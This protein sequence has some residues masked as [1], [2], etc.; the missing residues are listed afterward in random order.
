MKRTKK[1]V[2]LFVMACLLFS[3]IAACSNKENNTGSTS[4]SPSASASAPAEPVKEDPLKFVYH[5]LSRDV[6]LQENNEMYGWLKE[7]KNVD[8]K[9]VADRQTDKMVD[10]LNLMLASGDIPDVLELEN[11]PGA[12]EV[13]K[14]MGEAGLVI[15]WDEWLAKYPDLVANNDKAYDDAV[16]RAKDGNMYMLPINLAAK[17]GVLMAD[18]GPVIREDWLKAVGMS[19]PTTTDEL[20]EVLKAFRDQIP[21]VNGKKIIPATFDVFRQYIANAWTKSWVKFSEDNKSL[22]FQ[23][24]NPDIEE[25]MVFMNKLYREG[26]LDQEMLTQ[27]TDQYMEKLSSGR[28]GYTVRIYWDMDTVNKALKAENPETRFVPSPP[29]KVTGSSIVPV[30]SNPSDRGFNSLV[31]STEF[32]KDPRNIERLMEFLNWNASK[33]GTRMLKYGV[34]GEYY[35]KNAEGLYEETPESKE[36]KLVQNNTFLQRTGLDSYNLTRSILIPAEDTNPRSEEAKM[37]TEIWEA[38]IGEP[39][40]LEFQLTSAGPIEQQKWGV[41]W[42]ELDKW[43]SKAVFAKSE[44]ETRKITKEMLDAFEKNGG[45]D[46]VN[47]R[48]KAMSEFNQ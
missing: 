14:K 33:E 10:K 47:E 26:L 32:A 19:A 21:D 15:S 6:V 29:L 1:S 4:G 24:N 11:V 27:Q 20:Y 5:S 44:E 18:V 7:N 31:V 17:K 8:I 36:E 39:L 37:G 13:V 23:F 41:M 48:L 12:I 16:H 34:E 46:I 42:S 3:V 28:V 35:V 22:Q 25:Y 30:Y 40:P 9:A 38:S 45:R 43:T 2:T